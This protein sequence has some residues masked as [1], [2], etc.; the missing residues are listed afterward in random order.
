[1]AQRTTTTTTQSTL[2]LS[3]RPEQACGAFATTCADCVN[4]A[5]HPFVGA[6]RWCGDRCIADALASGCTDSVSV[7]ADEPCSLPDG[8]SAWRQ[9]QVNSGVVA[10]RLRWRVS[11]AFIQIEISAATDGYLS[12]GWSDVDVAHQS[13]DTIVA[14]LDGDGAARV[15]DTYSSFE[16]VQPKTDAVQNYDSVSLV[17]RREKGRTAISFVRPLITADADGD[18]DIEDRV[19]FVQWAVGDAIVV[20]SVD[21]QCTLNT[22]PAADP[23][24]YPEHYEAGTIALNFLAD[25]S[26]AEP[27]TASQ[28]SQATVSTGTV[29]LL[30]DAIV[31]FATI[32]LM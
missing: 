31:C 32:A 28:S 22:L 13:T 26:T 8:L 20:D 18:V 3:A 5:L 10:F 21:G 11:D 6:C 24:C 7:G 14:W 29:M 4:T 12:V 1:M 2:T 30:G 16:L 19:M 27:W 15:I 23:F 9:W 25:M 17:G